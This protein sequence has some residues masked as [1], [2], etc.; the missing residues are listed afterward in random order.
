MPCMAHGCATINVP[1]NELLKLRGNMTDRIE[2]LR[3]ILV[4]VEDAEAV[5]RERGHSSGRWFARLSA[6]TERDTASAKALPALLDCAEAL[7]NLVAYA[8]DSQGIAGYHMNGEVLE[9]DDVEELHAGLDALA[10]L[11]GDNH[12]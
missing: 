7:Q 11:N 1:P 5:Y 9:W 10:R 4:A 6:K 2:E 8:Q 3:A 12:A